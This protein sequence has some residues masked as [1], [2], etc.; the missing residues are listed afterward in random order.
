MDGKYE[1]NKLK[2]MG[3]MNCEAIEEDKTDM[4]I[5]VNENEMM[6]VGKTAKSDITLRIATVE[7]AAK[8]L[9]IYKFYVE[10]TAI[11]FEYDAPIL[12][13]FERRIS[14]TLN[15]YPYLV[16]ESDGEIVGY[17]YVS[18]FHERPAYDWAVETSIYMRKDCKCMGI[19]RMLYETLEKILMQQNILNI[20]ACIAYP[21]DGVEDEHLTLD[22]VKFH[23]K[24]GYR[25]VGEF[26]KCGYKFDNWYGMVWMEK[27]LGEHGVPHPAVIPFEEVR[28]NWE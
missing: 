7:D 22:S 13:E 24:M 3:K 16:A 5:S 19:G 14:K 4:G 21:T 1:V 23:E 28:R 11:T 6:S 20:E 18:A 9:E 25:M 27:H 17:A 12:E 26:K 8:L 15:R 2:K 10:T